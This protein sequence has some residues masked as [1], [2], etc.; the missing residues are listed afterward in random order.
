MEILVAGSKT[1][2]TEISTAVL[3]SEKGIN[4]KAHQKSF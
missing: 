3:S 1:N 4:S 2:F